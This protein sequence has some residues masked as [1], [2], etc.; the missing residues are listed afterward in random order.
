MR[1]IFSNLDAQRQAGARMIAL[2]TALMIPVV[3]GAK[4][5]LGEFWAVGLGIASLGAAVLGG[6]A[7]KLSANGSI[8][9][10]LSGVALMAQGVSLLV[11]AFTAAPGRSTCT[12][13]ISRPWPLLVVYCD[14]TVIAAARRRGG[15]PP[16]AAS[17]SSSPPRCSPGR[18]GPGPGDRATR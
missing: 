11:A 14:W 2:L 17:A 6:L 15:R 18:R 4:L 12:W 10:A 16:P 3:V 1:L 8:G 5:I 13:P 9:R 7:L